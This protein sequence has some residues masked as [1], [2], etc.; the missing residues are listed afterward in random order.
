MDAFDP[1]HVPLQANM[2]VTNDIPL[3]SPLPLIVATIK[4]VETLKARFH[5][6]LRRSLENHRVLFFS[7]LFLVAFCL[8]VQV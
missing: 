3:V 6:G 5:P 4:Y 2:R 1:A 8:F 7:F